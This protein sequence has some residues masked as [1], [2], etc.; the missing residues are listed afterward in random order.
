M[1]VEALKKTIALKDPVATAIFSF[2]ST[3][4]DGQA[5]NAS[6]IMAQFSI[7]DIKFYRARKLLLQHNFIIEHKK[8]S[9]DGSFAGVSY[10]VPHETAMPKTARRVIE[11]DEAVELARKLIK[12]TDNIS[13]DNISNDNLKPKTKTLSDRNAVPGI[14]ANYSDEFNYFW[15]IFTPTLGAKGSKSEA[16]K[17]WKKLRFTDSDVE[18][19]LKISQ[20]E[21]RRKCAVRKAG[22]WDP[23]FP[24]VCRILK[25][26][27][28]ETWAEMQVASPTFKEIMI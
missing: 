5:A 6:G 24:H 12:T 1:D 21:Y 22:E 28:W 23:N 2:L 19:V 9:H 27:L 7:G 26:R 25:Q 17:E 8:H 4:P 16:F 15:M 20:A 11:K 18:Q 14:T 3:L 10:S 13:N